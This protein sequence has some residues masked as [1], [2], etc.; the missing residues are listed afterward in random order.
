MVGQDEQHGN[1]FAAS[2]YRMLAFVSRRHPEVL[3]EAAACGRPIVTTE[4]QVA[5][6]WSNTT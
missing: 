2:V 6:T 4:F 5:A 3:L 1:R